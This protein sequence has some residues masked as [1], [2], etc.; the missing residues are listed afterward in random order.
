[1]ANQLVSGAYGLEIVVSPG[2]QTIYF[3]DV[4][5]LRG[6]RIKHIDLCDELFR[7]KSGLLIPDIENQEVEGNITFRSAQSQVNIIDNLDIKEISTYSRQ[8]NRISF[9]HIFDFSKSRFIY[10]NY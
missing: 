1:M 2:Q 5:V 4:A 9:N 7:S 10:K 8:G 3:P 6:K